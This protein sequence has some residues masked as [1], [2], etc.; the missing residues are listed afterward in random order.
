MR[1]SCLG[2]GNTPKSP[3]LHGQSSAWLPTYMPWNAVEAATS[4]SRPGPPPA[5]VRRQLDFGSD[6]QPTDCLCMPLNY[7]PPPPSPPTNQQEEE[8]EE[9]DDVFLPNGSEDVSMPLD[10]ALDVI[11]KATKIIRRTVMVLRHT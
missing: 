9:D 1:L 3:P 10:K 11:I 5:K 2:V 8:E 7:S 6:Q 4:P